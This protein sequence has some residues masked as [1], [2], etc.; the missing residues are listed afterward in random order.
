MTV[1]VLIGGRKK[2]TPGREECEIGLEK[3]KGGV[4]VC[5]CVCVVCV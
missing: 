2:G 1:V 4:C 3:K 5:V